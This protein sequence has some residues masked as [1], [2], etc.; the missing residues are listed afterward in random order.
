MLD[1]SVV[2]KDRVDQIDELMRSE[3]IAAAAMSCQMAV[4]NN[5]LEALRILLAAIYLAGKMDAS[6]IPPDP[7]IWGDIQIDAL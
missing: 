1:I 5:E 2:M 4:M 3:R 6:D 7:D